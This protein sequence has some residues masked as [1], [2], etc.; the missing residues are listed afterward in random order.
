M[1]I[2]SPLHSSVSIQS[3]FVRGDCVAVLRLLR[4]IKVSTGV[5]AW[6]RQLE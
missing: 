1:S 6:D 2:H 3:G 4:T 5:I